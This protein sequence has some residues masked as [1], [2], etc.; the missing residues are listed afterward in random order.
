MHRFNNLLS[1]LH[2]DNYVSKSNRTNHKTKDGRDRA[3][4]GY[5][6]HTGYHRCPTEQKAHGRGIIRSLSCFLC[7]LREENETGEPR[8][9]SQRE[10]TE[11]GNWPEHTSKLIL[12]LS[13]SP[14][15]TSYQFTII[16]QALDDICLQ[17]NPMLW[18]V[19]ING[20]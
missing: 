15:F 6:V 17:I 1:L 11:K 2:L 4:K 19:L 10:S 9:G 20:K 7:K 8:E 16:L 12:P 14:F 18:S 13:F 5:S 3:H